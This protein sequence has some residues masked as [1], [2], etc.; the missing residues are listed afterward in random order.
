MRHGP[1]A[2]VACGPCRSNQKQSGIRVSEML[3]IDCEHCGETSYTA[4]P[5]SQLPCP[6]CGI[7]TGVFQLGKLYLAKKGIR[8]LDERDRHI[9]GDMC[10]MDH[11]S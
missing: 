6:H 10:W 1:Q 4:D 8:P 3:A 2:R 7:R 11:C 5:L 9:G